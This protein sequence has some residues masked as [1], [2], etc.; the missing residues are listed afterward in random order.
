MRIW[1]KISAQFGNP[2]GFLGSIA[3]SIMATRTS[4]LERNVWAISLLNLRST[5]RVL[6]IGFGPGLAIQKM[7]DVVTEGVVWGI[8]HSHIMFERASV[9][10][11][12]GLKNGRVKLLLGSVASAQF[13]V[14][15]VDRILDI[16]S[17]QFW[18]SPVEDLRV[19]RTY[20][21]PGG[22]IAVVHQPRKPGSSDEDTDR[23]GI[24]FADYLAKAGFSDVSILKKSM[25]P[26]SAVCVLGRK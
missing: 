5:D 4:N 25:K 9:R 1:D 10:N 6:E 17:L 3:G 16:N 24:R 7:S 14:G 18:E 26:V 15:R 12:D 13:L 22:T 11:R 23:A 19:L 2:T 21:A 8:D 20:L